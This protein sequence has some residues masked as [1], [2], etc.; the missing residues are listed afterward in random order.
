MLTFNLGYLSAGSIKGRVIDSYTHETVIGAAVFLDRESNYVISGISGQYAFINIKPGT[1]IINAKSA[2]YENSVVQQLIVKSN[3]DTLSYDIY[4]KPKTT[5][6]DEVKVIGN[7]NKE[8]D[9]SARH[10]EQIASNVITVMSAK[11]IENLPDLNVANVMQRTSGVSMMKNSA[12]NNSQVVIRG[13]PPRYNSALV[14]GVTIPSTSGSS[15]SVPLDI[16][17][18]V[19]VGRIEVTKALTP[20][21]EAS[22]LGGVANVV[23]KDGPDTSILAVDAAT[24][25]NQYFL[26]N[27]FSTFNYGVVN[28]DDP[29]QLHG[30]DYATTYKDFPTANLVLKKIQAPPDVHVSVSYGNRYFNKKLGVLISGTYQTNYEGAVNNYI[31]PGAAFNTDNSDIDSKNNS[32]LTNQINRKAMVVKFDYAFNNYNQ[33]SLYST[34]LNMDEIRGRHDIDTTTEIEGRKITSD[35]TNLDLSNILS[36]TLHGKHTLTPSL[37]LDWSL[38]YAIA[39]SQ[40]PDLVTVTYD[41][42]IKPTVYPVYLSYSNCVTRLWQWNTDDNKSVYLNFNY[43]PIIKNHL[44]EF[45]FGGMARMKNRLNNENEYDFDGP[46]YGANYPNPDVIKMFSTNALYTKNI[47]Q[48]QGDAVYN[49]ANYKAYENI[50]A[51][52]VQVKTNFGKLQ[53]LTGARIEFT[54]QHNTHNIIDKGF[55]NIARDSFNYYDILPSLHLNYQINEKQN[56]RFS[57]YKALSRPNYTEIVPYIQKSANGN[58]SG[59]DTL[60]H[61]TGFCFDARY[62][63]YP[64]SEEVFTGGIFY[65]HLTN[66][67]EEYTTGNND[68]SFG[69]IPYC[70]NY[71]FELVA[72]KYFGNFGVNANYT[73]TRSSILVTKQKNLPDS[74]LNGRGRTIYLKEDRPLAGQSPNLINLALIYRSTR[75]GFKAQ[76]TYTMQGKNLVNAS[77]YFGLDGYQLNYS[78][79]GFSIEEYLYKNLVIYAKGSNLLN[80]IIKY[81]TKNGVDLRQ[82][83]SMRGFLIG[84]KFKI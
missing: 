17:P 78:D 44:F 35:I 27:K 36:N 51:G 47:Q 56:L 23:M 53:I 29:S 2:G 71:G 42:I 80:S 84:L 54:Y 10:S 57:V 77:Q 19:L 28:N 24:G 5:A 38:V 74:G 31:S 75:L 48:Q 26:N 43:K 62:E 45:K 39:N 14:D 66:A 76:L 68:K 73:F 13:M 69:N 72:I 21:M 30:V 12:G 7:I 67:I 6:I 8:T 4:L 83:S 1:Y 3:S 18:S 70:N 15:R 55:G 9:M 20:E 79:L 60:K 49:A 34:Y 65:K 61:T 22:G 32:V 58:T 33:I 59:N 11:T 64:E 52:Y 82:L 16:I 63:Y 46:Q 40:T 25:Y 37:D 41:Q 81:Q 50:E